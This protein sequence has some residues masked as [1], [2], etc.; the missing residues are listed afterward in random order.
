MLTN[1]GDYSWNDDA[2]Q[3]AEALVTE[4]CMVAPDTPEPLQTLA[5]VRLSQEKLEDARAAL[6]RSLGLWSDLGPEDAAQIPDFPTRISLARLLMEAEMEEQALEVLERLIAEDDHSVEAWYLG[7]W[8]L[9][10]L[11]DK[12]AT[13]NNTATTSE[14]HRQ[15][16]RT[17]TLKSSR[18]WLLK[19][20][21]LYGKLEYEDERLKGHAEELIAEMNKVLGPPP[22]DE[23]AEDEDDEWEGIEEDEDGDEDAVMEEV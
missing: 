8:C 21:K 11:A 1:H 15:D 10:L 3:R 22:E 4:A 16:E 13:D 19:C 20:M 7:G 12:K 14:G 23:N 9:H 6:T 17:R 5:S 18:L 2:E